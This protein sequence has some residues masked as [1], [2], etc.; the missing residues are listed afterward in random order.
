LDIRVGTISEAV[1]VENSDK[2][3]RLTVDFGSEIGIRTIFAGIKGHYGVGELTGMQTIFLAN[4]E[5]KKM[6]GG[7]SQGMLLAANGED[8][9]PVLLLLKFESP[10]GSVLM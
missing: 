8:G 9:K 3:I 1:E 7:E 10:N 6:P 5:P 2:L 4:L